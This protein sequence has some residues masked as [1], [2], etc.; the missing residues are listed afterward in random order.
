MS[1]TAIIRSMIDS[2]PRTKSGSNGLG[3]VDVD[4]SV[5]AGYVD[6]K[7]DG[8]PTNRVCYGIT[9]GLFYRRTFAVFFFS[10]EQNS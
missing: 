6:G 5:F 7:F 2:A 1:I 9:T 4:V 3:S 8:L 10:R